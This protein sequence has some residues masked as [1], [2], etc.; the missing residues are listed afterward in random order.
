MSS[1]AKSIMYGSQIDIKSTV[2]C[3]HS[4]QTTTGFGGQVVRGVLAVEVHDREQRMPQQSAVRMLILA[5]SIPNWVQS[6]RFAN[7]WGN[8]QGNYT[9]TDFFLTID[10]KDDGRDR[11]S[12]LDTDLLENAAPVVSIY[13]QIVPR[14]RS[15]PDL[16]EDTWCA[17]G[18]KVS[19]NHTIQQ[20]Y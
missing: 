1:E 3:L 2:C 13:S 17:S 15:W 19:R 11:V 20:G 7:P 14:L 16:E 9:Y 12:A 6:S 8:R 18:S 4:E 5:I 10:L